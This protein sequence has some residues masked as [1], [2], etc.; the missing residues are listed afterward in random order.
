MRKSVILQA[1]NGGR[2]EF[3]AWPAGS[4]GVERP[5]DGAYT[6]QFTGYVPVV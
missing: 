3:I 5:W 4:S 2:W 1:S 6:T